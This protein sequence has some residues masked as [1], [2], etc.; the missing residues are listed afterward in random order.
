LP[1]LRAGFAAF[2]GLAGFAAFGG[3]GVRRVAFIA[4]HLQ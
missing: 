1:A 4:S 2:G 3:L